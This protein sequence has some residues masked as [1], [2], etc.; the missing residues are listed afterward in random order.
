M[1]H[2][3]GVSGGLGAAISRLAGR[4]FLATFPCV[5]N[6]L[7]ACASGSSIGHAGVRWRR[8]GLQPW[9][10]SGGDWIHRGQ[11]AGSGRCKWGCV[12]RPRGLC[13]AATG[14]A[15]NDGGK[16]KKTKDGESEGGDPVFGI[17]DPMFGI[18]LFAFASLAASAYA[19]VPAMC[20]Q[21]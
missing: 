20:D 1:A 3:G 6:M 5:G 14:G 8:G 21:V 19:V 16:K 11:L 12:A 2:H 9:T 13:S 18:K 7:W 10:A 17:K 4:E 15:K